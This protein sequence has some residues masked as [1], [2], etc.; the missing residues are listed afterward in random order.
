MNAPTLVELRT[1]IAVVRQKLN[2]TLTKPL[3]LLDTTESV[4]CMLLAEANLNEQLQFRLEQELAQAQSGRTFLNWL[5]ALDFI[6]AHQLP[7]LSPDEW[8]R[9]T[10]NSVGYLKRANDVQ[11]AAILR[12]LALSQK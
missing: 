3:I 4:N 2:A 10:R 6:D 12:E 1:A 8:E 5:K 7:E 11:Q 9:F